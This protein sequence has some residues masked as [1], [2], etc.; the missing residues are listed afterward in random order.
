MIPIA[1]AITVPT[2]VIATI[3]YLA[4]ISNVT[5]GIKK[6]YREYW[7]S[8]DCPSNWDPRGQRV[9]LKLILFRNGDLP[10]NVRRHYHTQI[11][12]IKVLFCIITACY[13]VFIIMNFPD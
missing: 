2:L 9:Y 11:F 13:L 1:N 4:L 6:N 3:V 5:G 10:E 12:L 7:L 8:I